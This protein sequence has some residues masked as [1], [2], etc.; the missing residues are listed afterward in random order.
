M[1]TEKIFQYARIMHIIDI[2]MLQIREHF[3]LQ[4]SLILCIKHVNK[5]D[6]TNDMHVINNKRMKLQVNGMN[7]R[8]LSSASPNPSLS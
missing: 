4:K 2:K 5:N 6:N 7:Y 3:K 1:Q 8:S